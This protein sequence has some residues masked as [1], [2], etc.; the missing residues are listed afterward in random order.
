VLPGKLTYQL[1]TPSASQV[2][3]VEATFL[4]AGDGVYGTMRYFGLSVPFP[5]ALCEIRGLPPL[6]PW[7]ASFGMADGTSN[8]EDAEMSLPFAPSYHILT[9]DSPV[10]PL[11]DP[12]RIF[13]YVIGGQGVFL[14]ARSSSLEVLLPIAECR[15]PGLADVSP[16]VRCTHPPVP[17][18]LLLEIVER[19][20]AARGEHDQWLEMLFYLTWE[21]GAWQLHIPEQV[22]SPGSV[23][24]AE[25]SPAYV[26]AIVEGHSHH[27]MAAYFS[28]IDDGDE[29]L[30]GGFRVYFVLGRID[31]HPEIR[32]R[33]CVHG[34][35]WEVPANTLFTLPPEIHDCVARAGQEGL[36]NA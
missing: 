23:R 9:P 33:V 18:A 26:D 4:I 34:Y 16:Y 11:P 15:L 19:A 6:Y 5:L 3:P 29:L 31:T 27:T 7:L 8:L 22:Q 2:F 1:F 30:N 28:R 21:N 14:L 32:V 17:A 24:A 20:R 10:V 36:S 25:L 12:S 13:Q 35:Q